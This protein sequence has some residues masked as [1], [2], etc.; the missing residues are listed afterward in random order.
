[1]QK[2]PFIRKDVQMFPIVKPIENPYGKDTIG[3][4]FI[5]V[6]PKLFVDASQKYTVQE[7]TNLFFTVA[8]TTYRL[9]NQTIEPFNE[10]FT[11][12]SMESDAVRSENKLS[13][14]EYGNT[15][16]LAVTVPLSTGGCYLSQL[17]TPDTF[18]SQ[19][20][21]YISLFVLV[22]ATVLFSGFLLYRLL[23]HIVNQPVHILNRRLDQIAK[24]DFSH[25][26]TIE[27]EN[28]LGDIGRSINQLSAG[29]KE[30]MEK[31]IEDAREKKD[32]EYRMLQSQ[33]NPHF[34][35]NTLNSIKWMATIQNAP[36]IA[37]MVT[38][39]SRLLKNIAKGTE[40]IVTIENEFKLLDDY[41]VIQKYR[42]GG[43]ITMDYQVDEPELIQN[44]IPRFSLQ[45]IVENAIFHGI[46]PKGCEGH[47]RIHLYR[48]G[49]DIRIDVA[50]NGV[51]MTREA[52]ERTLASDIPDRSNFFKDVGVS[53]VHKRIL[54]TFGDGYGLSITSEP[55]KYTTMSL[56]LKNTLDNEKGEINH[57]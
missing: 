43:A 25:D 30:L 36:G 32:Y 44:K 20:N 3:F 10:D 16:G 7:N 46:E 6:N 1:M 26:D 13:S 8:G 17:L 21:E 23:S 28:E 55:G 24:G 12:T 5:E 33:I 4:V 47:I 54:Y 50:D 40:T 29:I 22:G 35:Y 19:M 53:S 52:I 41:F 31:R 14:V 51:G 45:P 56:L 18:M 34:L 39:L 27:W 49:A 48:S 9:N 57:V 37:E 42:Y 15:S 2:V 38:S 11:V